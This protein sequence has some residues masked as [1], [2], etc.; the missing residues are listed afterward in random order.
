[1]ISGS[2]SEGFFIGLG[3]RERFP[4]R[5]KKKTENQDSKKELVVFHL[6][7]G[8]ANSFFS[9]SSF[10]MMLR[11]QKYS[12]FFSFFLSFVRLDFLHLAQKGFFSC[13]TF[14]SMGVCACA[15]VRVC[16]RVCVCVCVC[17]GASACVWSN[18]LDRTPYK[19]DMVMAIDEG[20]ERVKSRKTG[21]EKDFFFP[22]CVELLRKRWRLRDQKKERGEVERERERERKGESVRR[23]LLFAMGLHS[24]FGQ[25][26]F[27]LSLSLSLPLSTHADTRTHELLLSLTQLA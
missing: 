6:R 10:R 8:F 17:E 18:C 2:P 22:F 15:F 4:S 25:S 9:S 16:L 3:S 27:S 13:R 26:P 21:K 11:T 7:P 19:R 1:M 23:A 5:S 20:T 12:W 14:A 24:T